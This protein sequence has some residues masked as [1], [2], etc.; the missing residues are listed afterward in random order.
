MEERSSGSGASSSFVEWVDRKGLIDLGFSGPILTWSHGTSLK[1]RKSARLDRALCN[2]DWRSLLHSTS[3]QHLSH[4]H[5][6]HCPLLLNL[7]ACKGK[8]L[9]NRPFRFLSAWMS[10][11]DFFGWTEWQ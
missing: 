9:G 2:E 7:K 5:S 4:D 10:H 11:G 3:V 8:H 6:D 1:T